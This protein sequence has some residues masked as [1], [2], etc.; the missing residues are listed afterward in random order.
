MGERCRYCG[1]EFESEVI[2]VAMQGMLFCDM[3]CSEGF[4]SEIDTEEMLFS[5]EE[6]L[7]SDIGV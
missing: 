5:R 7:A 4:V 6:I 1:R 2:I 3:G